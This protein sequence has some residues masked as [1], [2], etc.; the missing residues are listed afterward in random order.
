MALEASLNPKFKHT[1][2]KRH[3]QDLRVKYQR[4]GVVEC[5]LYPHKGQNLGGPSRIVKHTSCGPPGIELMPPRAM[6]EHRIHHH[7][8]RISKFSYQ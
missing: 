1:Y 7:Q 4:V 2:Q 6:D 3:P 8:R 5:V